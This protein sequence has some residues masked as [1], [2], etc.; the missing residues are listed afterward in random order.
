MLELINF[1]LHHID[2]LQSHDRLLIDL[3]NEWINFFGG[4]LVVV[5]DSL[6]D[7]FFFLGEHEREV[8]E[9]DIKGVLVLGILMEYLRFSNFHIIFQIGK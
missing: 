3:L 5:V 6:E 8:V 2:H 9:I 7:L 4:F 1:F